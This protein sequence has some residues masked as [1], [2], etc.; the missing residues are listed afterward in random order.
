MDRASARMHHPSYTPDRVGR[1]LREVRLH[2]GL[3]QGELEELTGI[4]KERISRYENGHVQARIENIAR[5]VGPCGMD[6]ATFVRG[7]E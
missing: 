6:L 4:P 3:S 7:L 1:H 5:L 2:G